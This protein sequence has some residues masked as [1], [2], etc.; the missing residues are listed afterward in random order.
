[1]RQRSRDSWELR[2][3]LGRNPDTG[4]E[5]WATRTVH[6]SRRQ[7][8]QQLRLL[9]NEVV[10]ARIHAGTF[11]DLLVIFD[12]CDYASVATAVYYFE[13]NGVW[14]LHPIETPTRLRAYRLPDPRVEPAYES[15]RPFGTNNFEAS[16]RDRA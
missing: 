10:A 8:S 9:A 16:A 1:M 5:R 15:F 12:D 4:K 7:V 6:G 13:V 14:R 3:Y 2:I 11:A